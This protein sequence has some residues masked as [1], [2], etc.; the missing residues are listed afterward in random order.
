MNKKKGTY[1]IAGCG[2]VGQHL[3]KKLL[4]TN[5]ISE[6]TA[7]ENI[8]SLLKSNQSQNKCQLLGIK[9]AL[10]DYDKPTQE[11]DLNDSLFEQESIIYYFIP[12]PRQGKKDTRA[13]VFLTALNQAKKNQYVK[14][15]IL[16]STSG[17]Y[18]HCYGRWVTEKI[19]IKPRLDR[20]LRRVDA[21]QQF[22]NYCQKNKIDLVILRVSGI[23]GP[24]KLPLKRIY[25]KT[26]IVRKQDSPCSNRIHIE[27]LLNIC[28]LAGQNQNIKGIF[29]CAD[30]HPST[31]YDYFNQIAQAYDLEPPPEITLSQAEKQLST[32]MLAYMKESR[33]I[34]NQKLLSSFAYRLKY[35]KL[36]L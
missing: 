25:A 28:V 2:Y 18:G 8:H 30:G 11:N 31:M 6:K 17:V 13:Q 26:P 12:P 10:V 16:I 27:D 21:E 36:K 14:K 22:Q 15:I 23:Y 24:D 1:L 29:N 3:V 9:T 19:K 5:E 33:K 32:G 35:P 4:V 34:N 20:A 7:K